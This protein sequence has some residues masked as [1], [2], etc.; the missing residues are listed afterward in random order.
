M[1]NAKG[2][3][4]AGLDRSIFCLGTESITRSPVLTGVPLSS[5]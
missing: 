2:K 1:R 4:Q 3:E 5:S